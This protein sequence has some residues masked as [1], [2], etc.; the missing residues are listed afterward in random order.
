MTAQMSDARIVHELACSESVFWDRLFFDEEFNRRLFLEELRF[1][2]WRVVRQG[3]KNAEVVE[4]ELDVTPAVGDLPGPLRAI[5]GDG[6]SYR[7]LGRY[8]RQRRSYAVKARSNTLGDRLLVDGVLTTENL[9]EHRCRRIFTVSVVAKIFG[10]AG[11]LEKR[12]LSDLEQS[13]ATSARFIDR[14]AASLK[15][16]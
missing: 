5:I 12:V 6:L 15:E 7:E 13:Y 8:D 2:A 11:M 16:A 1:A 3:D 10:V 4:R 14:Y 9:G